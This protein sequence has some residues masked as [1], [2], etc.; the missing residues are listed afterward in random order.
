[1]KKRNG[2][3]SLGNKRKKCSVSLCGNPNNQCLRSSR[4]YPSS[5]GPTQP[6]KTLLFPIFL[7]L[8]FGILFHDFFLLSD[9]YTHDNHR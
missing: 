5:K 8:I 3:N 2:A 4:V 9:S 1:M 7:F 6:S